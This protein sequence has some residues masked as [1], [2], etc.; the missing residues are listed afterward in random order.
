M[1][2]TLRWPTSTRRRRKSSQVSA[3]PSSVSP[4]TTN[5]NRNMAMIVERREH[6]AGHPPR[7]GREHRQAPHGVQNAQTSSR[8]RPDQPPRLGERQ[9]AECQ[10]DDPAPDQLIAELERRRNGA[11]G[12]PI[13][14]PRYPVVPGPGQPQT[15]DAGQHQQGRDRT[16]TDGA[17]HRRHL[18]EQLLGRR[19]SRAATDPDRAAPGCRSRGRAPPPA[20]ELSPSEP[21]MPHPDDQRAPRQRGGRERP[22]E[23]GRRPPE[24][25]G[26]ERAGQQHR[27][28]PGELRRQSAGLVQPERRPGAGARQPEPLAQRWRDG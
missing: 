12:G 5:G 9:Q 13:G 24:G 20:R 23:P 10:P 14:A 19:R 6:R 2:L 26:Q 8:L 1:D 27:A 17:H 7:P 16:A 25:Q 28:G 11:G 15:R 18:V 22:G 21:E 4:P 3:R